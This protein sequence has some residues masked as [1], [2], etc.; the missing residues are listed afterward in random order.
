LVI[1]HP[2]YSLA[3]SPLPEVFGE[4]EYL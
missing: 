2:F 1:F 3:P 4:Y